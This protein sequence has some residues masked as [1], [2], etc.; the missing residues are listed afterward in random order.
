MIGPFLKT[1]IAVLRGRDGEWHS[2]DLPF[3]RQVRSV[4]GEILRGSVMRLWT[5]EAWQYRAK[6]E[7]DRSI[8]LGHAVVRK[9]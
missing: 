5:G 4:E 8:F 3:W 9:L 7:Q 6:T 1:A 2:Y